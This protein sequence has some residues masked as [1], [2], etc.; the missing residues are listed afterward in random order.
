MNPFEDTNEKYKKS[1]CAH[2]STLMELHAFVCDL[3]ASGDIS[4]VVFTVQRESILD[5]IDVINKELGLKSCRT[6]K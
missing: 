4:D 5:R 2:K 1:L 6:T 3:Y